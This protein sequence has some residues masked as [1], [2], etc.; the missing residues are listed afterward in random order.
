MKKILCVFFVGMMLF[1]GCAKEEEKKAVCRLEK[2]G[3]SEE[4]ALNAL[5]DQVLNTVSVM[6]LPFAMYEIETEEEKQLFTEQMMTG[7]DYAGI[8][9]ETKSTEDEF[10]LE[11]T[12]DY[13]VV[14]FED[15]EQ[16]GMIASEEVDSEIVSFEKTLESLRASGYVCE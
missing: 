1:S 12:V 5:N 15:L 14:S 6:K 16:L 3:I 13:E 11:M 7:F 8:T 9:V 4:M 2:D 10:V